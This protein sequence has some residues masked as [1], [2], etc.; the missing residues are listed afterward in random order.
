MIIV[1]GVN[2]GRCIPAKALF[3][4]IPLFHGAGVVNIA[5]S[6]VRSSTFIIS[7]PVLLTNL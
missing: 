2:T 1:N 5:V 7:P 6:S 3:Q 4:G